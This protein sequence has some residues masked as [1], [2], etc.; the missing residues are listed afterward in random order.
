[1]RPSF[2]PLTVL[3]LALGLAAGICAGPAAARSRIKDIVNI[4][5]VRDN[6]L[7]GYGV[8]VGLNGTG[9]ACATTPR[10]SRAWRTCSSGRV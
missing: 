5:G 4:E 10:P 7:V 8:V 1:M 9:D 6:Q 3:A 2:R